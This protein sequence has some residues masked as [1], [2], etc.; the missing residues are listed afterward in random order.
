MNFEMNPNPL[1]RFLM[2][3]PQEFTKA[4]L[5]RFVKENRIEMIN[6]RYPGAE[7]RLKTLNFIINDDD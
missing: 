6:L 3:R 5:V 2:K 4:D 1:V 7:G